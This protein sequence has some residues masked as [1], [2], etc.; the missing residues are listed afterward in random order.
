MKMVI[1]IVVVMILIMYH[2]IKM[3][4]FEKRQ[5]VLRSRAMIMFHPMTIIMKQH[6]KLYQVIVLN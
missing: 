4:F 1:V 6:K 2:L 5:N 3:I